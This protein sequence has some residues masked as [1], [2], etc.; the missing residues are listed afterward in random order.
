MFSLTPSPVFC[1]LTRRPRTSTLFPYTTLFR[2][3]LLLRDSEADVVA[4]DDVEGMAN[5]LLSRF[6]QYRSGARPAPLSVN[7]SFASRRVQAGLLFDAIDEVIRSGQSRA[8]A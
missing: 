3:E 8:I 1:L 5:A 4:P 2:S 6:R 7:M